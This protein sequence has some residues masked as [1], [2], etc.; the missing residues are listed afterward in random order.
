V[1]KKFLIGLAP[2]VVLAAFAAVPA[3]QGAPHVYKNGVIA[4]EGTPVRWTEWGNIV[5]FNVNFSPECKNIV[6]GFLENP[7]GGGTAIGKVEAW[8]P[9]EC[10]SAEC[11]KFG[12]KFFEMSAEKMPW[13]A[14]VTE[15]SAGAFRQKT[16]VKSERGG[17]PGRSVEFLV[18]CEGFVKLHPFGELSPLILN[19]GTTIGLKPGEIEF[20]KE[21]SGELEEPEHGPWTLSG[22]LKTQGYAAQELIE[23][24]NP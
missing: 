17:G 12:G 18:N 5:F 9:F 23:V 3:A 1:K 15:P 13:A 7:V 11:T 22:K 14:S 20:Q 21:A 24:R 4:K 2:L 19:N 8:F 16:G 6:A 10:V